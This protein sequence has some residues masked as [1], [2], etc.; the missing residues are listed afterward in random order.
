MKGNLAERNCLNYSDRINNVRAM[1]KWPEKG[2]ALRE[3]VSGVGRYR[4]R[5]EGPQRA[6]SSN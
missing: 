5:S 3:D 4:P 1:K 2:C 6:V